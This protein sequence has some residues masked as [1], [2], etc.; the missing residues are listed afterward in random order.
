MK[1]ADRPVR[2]ITVEGGEGAGKTTLIRKLD[3]LFKERG[4]SVLLTREPGGTKLGE[5]IR[6]WLLN[7]GTGIQ[8]DPV[9]ELLLFLTAR[10]QHIHEVIKP[11]LAAGK[12]VICDRFNDSSVAYQGAGRGLGVPFV[13][14]LCNTVCGDPVPDLTYYLDVDPRI[15]L[16]R[17]RGAVKENAKAGDLDRIEAEANAFHERVRHAFVAM[18]KEDPI[19][20]RLIDANAPKHVVLHEAMKYV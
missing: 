13:R 9:A 2:F 5:Q 14:N 3:S 20:F 1:R 11:A 6:L 10:S 4:E 17:T 16:Q 7:R 19:R 15:G 12:V 8:I 18:A